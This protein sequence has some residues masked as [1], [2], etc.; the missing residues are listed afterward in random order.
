MHADLP[1]ISILIFIVAFLYAS[2][3]H[4]GA[5][6]YLAILSLFGFALNEM[7]STALILNV[8]VA[9]LALYEYTR[10]GYFSWSLTWPFIIA[11]I[12]AAFLGGL[13]TVSPQTYGL[14]LAATLLWASFRLGGFNLSKNDS[15]E[16]VQAIKPA[17][18]PLRFSLPAG[19][20]IGLISGMVGVGGGIFL[21]PL[22][23][24]LKWADVKPVAATSAFFIVVNAVAGLLGRV[25]RGGL[26]V[27]DLLP[28]LLAAV[29]GGWLGSNLGAQKF[30]GPTLRR[31]L[32]VVLLIAAIKL[33]LL[34]LKP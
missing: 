30:S 21:S 1:L 7:A 26:I 27:G 5:S 2:V 20:I 3:G 29:A 28:F 22:M 33:V 10:G 9:G 31:L 32:A 6:G 15:A 25:S 12:P 34:V 23:L 11:S 18:I 24:I 14:L 16:T 8:V 17:E 4:G 19:G 13:L